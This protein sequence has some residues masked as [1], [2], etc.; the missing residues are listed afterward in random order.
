MIRQLKKYLIS[1]RENASNYK[2]ID[3]MLSSTVDDT[4]NSKINISQLQGYFNSQKQFISSLS[5]VEFQVFSQ[6]G[7]DGILQ[8]LISKINV[9]YKTFVEFGVEN[10]RESNTR[11]LFLNNHWSGYVIDGSS[12]NVRFLEHDIGSFGEL[13]T[14]CAFITKE[15]INELLIK[16]EFNNEFGVLSID[17]DGNDYWVWQEIKDVNPIIVIA[18]YN[19][20]FGVNTFWSIPYKANFVRKYNHAHQLYYGASLQAL[21]FLAQQKGYI[22]I[23]CNSKGNNAFF[24]RKDKI[25]D[26]IKPPTVEQGYVES[27]FREARDEKGWITGRNRIKAIEGLAVVDVRTDSIQAI[28]PDVV[29]Y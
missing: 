22:F 20:V 29:Q 17:I 23:G 13:H 25:G 19:S 26:F 14:A 12:D 16:P 10:Y 11:Y 5:E 15:N 1:L 4:K 6:G 21:N 28:D 9:P 18:E 27:K 24:L 8:Y 3:L 2:K 7:E